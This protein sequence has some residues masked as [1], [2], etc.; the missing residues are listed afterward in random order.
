[1]NIYIKKSF[2]LILLFPFELGLAQSTQI[3]TKAFVLE[4]NLYEEEAEVL[5]SDKNIFGHSS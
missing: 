5:K 4:K 2:F 1:M 3:Q